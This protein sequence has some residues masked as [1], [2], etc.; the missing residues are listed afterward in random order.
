M[1]EKLKKEIKRQRERIKSKP[2][3]KISKKGKKKW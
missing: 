2:R 1:E 3:L